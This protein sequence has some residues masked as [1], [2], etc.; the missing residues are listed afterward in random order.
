MKHWRYSDAEIGAVRVTVALEDGRQC[1]CVVSPRCALC[2]DQLTVGL[3]A[4]SQEI[5]M[6]CQTR[7]NIVV[8]LKQQEESNYEFGVIGFIVRP[9]FHA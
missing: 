7:V 5:N 8:Q 2:S 9:A 6:V 3:K 1:K 4:L